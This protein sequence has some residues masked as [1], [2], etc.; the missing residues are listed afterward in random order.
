MSAY[1]KPWRLEYKTM[2]SNRL[3]IAAD[4][5]EVARIFSGGTIAH[6]L[7]EACNLHDEL[8]TSLHNL[9]ALMD[10]HNWR[11]NTDESHIVTAARNTLG[12]VTP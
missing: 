6:Q 4:G 3:I 10:S 5:S 1:P 9:I 2:G 8:R 7:L 11:G 12:K